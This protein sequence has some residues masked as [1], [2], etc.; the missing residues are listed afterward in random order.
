MALTLRESNYYLV[1]LKE[2]MF[3]KDNIMFYKD[4]I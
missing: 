3:Y 2:I 1:K 4:N